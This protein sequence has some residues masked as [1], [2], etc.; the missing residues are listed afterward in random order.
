MYAVNRL[1]GSTDYRILDYKIDA[2]VVEGEPVI[3]TVTGA[4]GGYIADAT[5]TSLTNCAGLV[6]GASSFNPHGG[7]AGSLT[8]STTQG[9]TEGLARVIINPDLVFRARMSGGATTGT[10][11]TTLS[12]TAA[13]SGGTTITDADVG[14]AAMDDAVVWCSK[15]ANLGQSRRVTTFNSATSFV[16]TVPF[17]RAIAVGDEFLF[18]PFLPVF[19]STIQLTSDF[20]EAD[21]SI[22][23]ATGANAKS[24]ELVLNGAT[25]SYVHFIAR[26]H[27]YNELS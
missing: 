17:S 16:V 12:N 4:T 27:A 9:D 13:S 3:A 1:D 11:L 6:I 5:T 25:D 19:T 26:D 24:I 15:G 7:G 2:T 18:C 14:S 20:L 21:A 10:A 8:Y 22:A 23:V